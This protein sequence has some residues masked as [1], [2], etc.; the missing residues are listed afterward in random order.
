M[1]SP[2]FAKNVKFLMSVSLS[3][4]KPVGAL[5]GGRVEPQSSSAGKLVAWYKKILTSDDHYRTFVSNF[6]MTH[7]TA[8]LFEVECKIKD[9]RQMNIETVADPDDNDG[10][11]AHTIKIGNTTYNVRGK[12]VKHTGSIRKASKAGAKKAIVTVRVSNYSL[13]DP[14]LMVSGNASLI[15]KI[16]A[17]Y[18]KVIKRGDYF[19]SFHTYFKISHLAG[20]L[21]AIEYKADAAGSINAEFLASAPGNVSIKV[22]KKEY[23]VNGQVLHEF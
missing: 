8:G 11:R 12:V 7:V 15:K 6:K 20:S 19:K 1:S 17:L 2:T 23:L 16:I 3:E 22:N 10:E 13:P 14:E 9:T 4:D 5:V 21:F 18:N